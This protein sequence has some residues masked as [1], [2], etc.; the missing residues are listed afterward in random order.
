M[1]GYELSR[2]VEPYVKAY[3]IFTL[4]NS[5]N[6]SGIEYNEMVVNLWSLRRRIG[7][8]LFYSILRY[9]DD[10]MQRYVNDKETI[11]KRIRNK[12]NNY[13]SKPNV[14]EWVFTAYGEVCISCGSKEDIQLDHVISI[15]KCGKNTL[16][17]LQP[18][19]KSCNVSKRTKTIDYR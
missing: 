9:V 17:N 3:S 4:C 5:R 10:S 18:L 13:I 19:C 14:R 11:R 2:H 1:T 12:A 6:I 7:H 16:S 15:A 8:E